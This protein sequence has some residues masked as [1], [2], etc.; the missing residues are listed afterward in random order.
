MRSGNHHD[1]NRMYGGIIFDIVNAAAKRL[2][3][4]YTVLET[5]SYGSKTSNG[6]WNGII[7]MVNQSQMDLGA[8]FMTVNEQR[9]EAVT[10]IKPF[11]YGAAG[12]AL[13]ATSTLQRRPIDD[14]YNIDPFVY[15]FIV[16][17]LLSLFGL[18][19]LLRFIREKRINQ[20]ALVDAMPIAMECTFSCLIDQ[21]K[22]IGCECLFSTSFDW[23]SIFGIL[24]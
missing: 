12:I 8:S 20:Q 2:N 16:G 18:L 3:F 17:L 10:F 9:S 4:T 19:I 24:D 7:G 15:L 6:T 23:M 22:L 14:V 5:T 11:H 13:P 1:P 21:S